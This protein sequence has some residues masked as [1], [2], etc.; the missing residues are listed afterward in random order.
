MVVVQDPSFDPY[1]FAKVATRTASSLAGAAAACP[2]NVQAFF[3]TIFA[4]AT[5]AS[6]L[7]DIN[8]QLNLCEDAKMTSADDVKSRLAA[9]VRVMWT[10]A[11]SCSSLA[12]GWDKACCMVYQEI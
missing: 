4:M 5:T 9:Y 10:N 7:Q 1:G 3:K 11:V 8:A 2:S 6:G 12:V